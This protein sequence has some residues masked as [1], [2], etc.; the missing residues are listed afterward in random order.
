MIW[1]GRRKVIQAL[2]A[3]GFAALSACGDD[4]GPPPGMPDAE[5]SA[6]ANPPAAGPASPNIA[7]ASPPLPWVERDGCPF[8]CCVYGQWESVTELTVFAQEGDTSTIAFILPAG[9][10]FTAE[11]GNVHVLVPGLAVAMDTI[12]LGQPGDSSLRLEVGDTVHVLGHQ[13]EGVFELWSG[14]T[15]F[16][17]EAFWSMMPLSGRPAAGRLISE[18]VSEWWVRISE[19]GGRSG[20]IE[21][22]RSGQAV[23]GA[24]ACA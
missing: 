6:T 16:R 18:P 5:P 15:T 21:M 11:T 8:E 3:V 14:G 17:G 13:G 24:D 19:S 4:G 22:G 10:R 20:W 23:R 1:S 9:Q 7:A 12:T 2:V